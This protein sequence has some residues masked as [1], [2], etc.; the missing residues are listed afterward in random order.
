MDLAHFIYLVIITYT[1]WYNRGQKQWF[2]QSEIKVLRR[3][4]RGKGCII[5][6][7]KTVSNRELSPIKQNIQPRF[8]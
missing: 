5:Y 2:R 3:N 6:N 8:L 4:I 7:K 1:F